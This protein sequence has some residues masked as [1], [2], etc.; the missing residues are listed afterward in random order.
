[1]NR[2]VADLGGGGGTRYRALRVGPYH[3]SNGYMV[4]HA[5]A[6]IKLTYLFECLNKIGVVTRLDAKRH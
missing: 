4:W 2:L 6:V 3:V 1:M 5:Y